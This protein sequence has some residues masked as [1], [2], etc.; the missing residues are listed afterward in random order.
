MQAF[1]G[2]GD[3]GCFH[4]KI[5]LLLRSYGK[6]VSSPVIILTKRCLSVN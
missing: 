5:C 2:H 3:V 1:L 6:H 4:C